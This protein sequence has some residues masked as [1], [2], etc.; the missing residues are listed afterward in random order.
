MFLSKLSEMDL[1]HYLP[2]YVNVYFN[3]IKVAGLCLEKRSSVSL[4]HITKTGKTYKT[5]VLHFYLH[6]YMM[7]Y[8]EGLGNI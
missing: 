4:E 3:I 2:L 6:D 7:H 8:N 1:R 5:S